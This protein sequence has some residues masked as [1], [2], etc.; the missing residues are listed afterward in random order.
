MSRVRFVASSVAM[1][2]D[3]DAH[4]LV[5]VVRAVDRQGREWESYNDGPYLPVA[6]P[7]AIDEEDGN[8]D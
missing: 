3:P 4:V 5:K 7:I 6:M 8:S 2:Y 1:V